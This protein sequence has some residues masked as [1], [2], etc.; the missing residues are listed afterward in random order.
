MFKHVIAMVVKSKLFNRSILYNPIN[1]CWLLFILAVNPTQICAQ[2]NVILIIADDIGT[3]YFGCYEDFQDTANMPNIRSLLARGVRF[4]NATSNPVCSPTRA[5]ILTGQYSFRTGIGDVVM[6]AGSP[7]LDTS[8]IT[9]PRL[10]KMSNPLIKTANIGKWHL[11][12]EKPTENLLIPNVVGYDYYAGNFLGALSSYTNWTKITNGVSSTCT[13][14]ATT[15]LTNDAINWVQNQKGNPFFLW[16][17]YNAPHTPLHLPP[18]ALHSY[19]FLSG[20]TQDINA[21]PKMYF[22]AMLEALDHEI[23]RLFDSLKQYNV[24]DSTDIIFI[25]DNGNGL[26]TAQIANTDRAKGTIYE[27]GVHVPFIVSGPS[28]IAPNRTS[29]ALVNTHDIFATVNDMLGYSLWKKNVPLNKTIDSKSLLPVLQNN[30]DSIRPWSFTEIFK[31]VSDSSEGMAIR[32]LNYKLIQFE[33]GQQELYNLSNDAAETNNLILGT[34][35]FE[36]NLNYS[37][38]CNQLTQLIGKAKFCADG[39]NSNNNAH[40]NCKVFPN[41]FSKNTTLQFSDFQEHIKI[42]VFN[43]SGV[44][45]HSQLASGFSIDLRLTSLASGLYVLKLSDKSGHSFLQRIMVY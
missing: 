45:L 26:R 6:G 28:I 4:T 15:E 10:L 17:A 29:H 21:Q 9:L 14:Y 7:T 11:S 38:L 20:T 12:L 25:G 39:L 43:A 40:F 41:P 16:L 42:E 31:V 24:Y 27:Y 19:N 36:D 30:S 5:G 33:Y 34:L 44:C 2:R 35:S 23:G 1:W 37:F 18:S 32:N 8:E 22:K 3:D 13:N